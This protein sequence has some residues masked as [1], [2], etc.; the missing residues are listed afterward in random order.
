MDKHKLILAQAF[1]E[2]LLVKE[3]NNALKYIDLKKPEKAIALLKKVLKQKE[4]KEAWLNL[5]VAYKLIGNFDKVK[6]CFLKAVDANMPL[7][8][9][10]YLKQY[11]I[12]LNNL[13][14]LAY[15]FEHDDVATQ[16][17]KQVLTDDPLDYD[18][19]WN[20]AIVT[21]RRFCSGKPEDLDRAWSYYTYRFKRKNAESLKNDNP[22]LKYWNFKDYHPESGIVLLIEQGLGDSFMFGR[23]IP[24]VAKHFKT[25][26]IQ[27]PEEMQWVFNDYKTC[28][29]NIDIDAEYAVPIASLG[30]ILDHIPAGDWLK[31]RYTPKVPNGILDIGV[32]WKGNPGHAND[33]NRSCNP[34]YF[35]RL[36]KYANLYTIGP[37]PRRKGYGHVG[38]NSWEETFRDMSK[39]DLVISIDSSIVHACG[40]AG[41]PCWLLMPKLDTD[42]RWGDTDAGW[43]NVWY[44]SVDVFRNPNDWEKV[45]NNVEKRIEYALSAR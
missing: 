37:N 3:F 19:L 44:D 12:G 43:N 9:G 42:F 28:I 1:S 25:V 10:T 13:G 40:S 27:C 38:G 2:G 14:L 26:Y 20:L 22:N 33:A 29:S 17:Y 45:F 5:G 23:Y 11:N 41:M 8:D 36:K 31:N 16:F 15:S 18:A 6:E 32:V 35:D 24:E 4:F 39:L 21:L 34:G 30:K 7:S